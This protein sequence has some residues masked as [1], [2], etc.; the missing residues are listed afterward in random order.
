MECK[1]TYN[2]A[3]AHSSDGTM[4]GWI[5]NCI[6]EYL[7]IIYVCSSTTVRQALCSYGAATPNLQLSISA[8]QLHLEIAH[9]IWGSPLGD[10]PFIKPAY[11]TPSQIVH[12]ARHA[13]H[14][15]LGPWEQPNSACCDGQT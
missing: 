7:Q 15:H 5:H 2:K 14:G 3:G 6:P 10:L 13:G 8:D 11:G 4:R 1:A 12:S 9:S